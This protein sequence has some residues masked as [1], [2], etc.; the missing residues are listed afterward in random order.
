MEK[1]RTIVTFVS[2]AAL[3]LGMATSGGSVPVRADD[4]ASETH[5]GKMHVTKN[6]T[7]GCRGAWVA[8]ARA[9][10]YGIEGPNVADVTGI[11]LSAGVPAEMRACHTATIDGYVVEGH[12]PFSALSELLRNRPAVTGCAAPG[13]PHGSPGMGDDLSARYSVMAFGGDAGAG[14]V[15]Y[16]A[17]Q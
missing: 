17:G 8:L 6:R 5:H 12:L 16:R 2:T 9:E 15:F 14:K 4:H 13:M 1:S 11:K 7:Y 3:A 10:G